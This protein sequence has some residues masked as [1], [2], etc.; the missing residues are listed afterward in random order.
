MNVDELRSALH[1]FGMDM[2][3]DE[4]KAFVAEVDLDKNGSINFGEFLNVAPSPPSRT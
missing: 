3:K 1:K 2:P 4:V